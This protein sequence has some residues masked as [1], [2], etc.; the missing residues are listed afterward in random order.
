M[1]VPDI[2]QS[3]PIE[4]F[5]AG[6]SVLR[7][8]G[9]LAKL[10]AHHNFKLFHT[11]QSDFIQQARRYRNFRFDSLTIFLEFLGIKEPGYCF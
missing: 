2:A 11:D 10:G 5:S 3:E 4:A 8:H 6:T 9:A 1:F 7:D